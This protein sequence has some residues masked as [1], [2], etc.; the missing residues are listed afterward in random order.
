M[1][2]EEHLREFLDNTVQD[3]E[4]RELA[5]AAVAGNLRQIKLGIAERLWLARQL[6]AEDAAASAT[7]LGVARL[8]KARYGVAYAEYGRLTGVTPVD[9]ARRPELQ[10]IEGGR[11]DTPSISGMPVTDDA[12]EIP[13]TPGEGA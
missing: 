5:V 2:F 13:G 1:K 7:A 11:P 8:L 10:V 12:S 3:A 4:A 6:G 9:Q